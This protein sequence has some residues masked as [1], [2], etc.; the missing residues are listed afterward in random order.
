MV[1]F[2]VGASATGC[3]SGP[4]AAESLQ[5]NAD[6]KF[7]ENY[8]PP[9]KRPP[10]EDLLAPPSE[11]E[12]KAWNRHDPA[13]EKHLYKWDKK[14]AA[15]MQNYAKQLMCY[16]EKMKEEGAKAMTA[17]PM[18][19]EFEAWEQFKQAFIP[20][21]NRWQQ[22]LQ[23]NEPRIKEK[24]KTM[25]F[26]F[27]AHELIING[28]PKAYNSKDEHQLKKVEAQWLLANDKIMKYWERVGAPFPGVKLET[29]KDKADWEKFCAEALVEPKKGPKKVR[30]KKGKI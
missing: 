7:E 2:G 1:C 17:E 15:K 20:F 18:T 21:V 12:F 23:A 14:N 30:G 9:P 10:P 16:R 25:G 29:D 3:D 5:T 6:K 28:Y 26:V 11:A 24:S 22:R 13:G 27:E 19:P 8:K 4:S